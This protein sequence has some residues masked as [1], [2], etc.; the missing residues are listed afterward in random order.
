MD[1]RITTVEQ[2]RAIMGEPNKLVPKKLW[3]RLE[4]EAVE[5]IARSPFLLL[6]TSDAEGNQD[7]SPKG[8][9]AGFVAIEDDHTLLIPDRRG[10]K[11]LFGLQNILANPHIGLIFL[12]PGTGE[13]LR[14]NGTAEITTDPE[15]LN[16]LSAR[17]QAAA[18]AIRVAVKECFF[19]CAKAFLR[20]KLWEPES[21][22]QSQPIS[23]GR[24][25]GRRAGVDE[26]TINA[27]DA[28]IAAD[29]KNNL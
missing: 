24:M 19:H 29:Y 14:V 13:T 18:L 7:V 5:F 21:W 25:L 28:A 16:R 12:V 10:N 4:P 8:D 11:L 9:G 20:A 15:I 3:T 26:Q 1:Y 6:A 23:F 17:N 22:P 2:L 27:L